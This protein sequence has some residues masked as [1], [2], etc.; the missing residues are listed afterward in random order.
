MR[1]E[2]DPFATAPLA[3]HSPSADW[4]TSARPGAAGG[5]DVRRTESFFGEAADEDWFAT[6]PYAA[7]EHA[8]EAPTALVDDAP[9]EALPVVAPAGGRHRADPDGDADRMTEW[10]APRQTNM[11]TMGLLAALLV[12]LG[13]FAG[14]IVGRT[15]GAP[16]SSGDTARP[17]ATGAAR[18]GPL[19]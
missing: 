19:R 4:L 18:P 9:T 5:T 17:A 15:A 13:F 7:E 16:S 6:S 3:A 8:A 10:R 14:V 12:A 11:V 2:R 1:P